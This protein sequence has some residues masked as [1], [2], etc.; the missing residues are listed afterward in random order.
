MTKNVIQDKLEQSLTEFKN[1]I[2]IECGSQLTTYHELDR[3]SNYMANW[4]VK[5]SIQ[6]GTFV[7][8]LADDRREFITAMIALLKVGGVFVALDSVNPVE[9]LRKM[10]AITQLKLI[11][12]D[13][14]NYRRYSGDDFIRNSDIEFVV[15]EDFFQNEEVHESDCRTIAGVDYSPED[16]IYVYFTSGT[17]GLPKAVVGKNKSLLHY[18]E[19]EVDTFMIDESFRMSQLATTGFDAFLKEVFVTLFSGGIL[20]VP[21]DMRL[22][23]STEEL[24]EWLEK[25]EIHLL[26]CVPGIF[27]I[28]CSSDLI[29]SRFPHLR[30]ILMSGEKIVPSN[31]RKWY[32]VFTE[33]V[34]LVNLYGTT[35]TTILKTCYLINPADADKKVI[36]IGKPIRGCRMIILDENMNIC[37]KGIIGEIY[38]RTPYLTYGYYNDPDLTKKRFI[39]NPFNDNPNDIIYR[40]GDLG[41]F[42]L[43]GNVECLG[44]IDRQVKVRGNRI[45]LEEIENALLNY[46]HEGAGSTAQINDLVVIAKK[47]EENNNYLCA[48]FISNQELT[49]AELRDYL[50]NLMPDYMIP[51]YFMRIEK[52]PF[53]PNGKID[54]TALP[55]PVTEID[56]QIVSPRN[57]LEE[58]LAAIW[59][60]VLKMDKGNISVV[61]NFFELGG[62]SL[63]VMSL[64]SLIHKEFDV[65]IPVGDIFNN[66]TIKKQA[67]FISYSPEYKDKFVSIQPAEEKD[68]YP[69]SSG[70][71]RLYVWQQM[72]LKSTVYNTVQVIVL[73]GKQTVDLLEETFAKLIERHE[74]LRTSFLMI[75]E[76]PVQRVH[77]YGEVGSTFAIEH[78]ECKVKDG[79]TEQRSMA[80]QAIVDCFIRPFDLRQLPLFR[81]AFINAG[82]ETYVLVVDMHHIISD[83]RANDILI[84]DFMELF[85]RKSLKRLKLQYRDFSEWQ[86]RLSR[87]GLE[88]MNRM[89][90]YWLKQFQGEIPV[91]NLPTDFSR[92][93]MPISEGNSVY[94]D[95]GEETA[96]ALRAL[97]LKEGVTLYILLVALFNVLLSRL[98]SQE[99]IIVGIM[100]EG[101]RHVDLENIIGF[102]VNTLPLRN[103][104]GADKPFLEFL[105]E[106]KENTLNALEN[107]D[108][109]FE[110]LLEKLKV[111]R[112]THGNPLFN[113]TIEIRKQENAGPG[114]DGDVQAA[115]EAVAMT[116]T[117]YNVYQ[118]KAPFD[119]DFFVSDLGNHIIIRILYKTE[120][121]KEDTI[122]RFVSYFHDLVASVL[123]NNVIKLEDIK[124][125]HELVDVVP[126]EF[127]NEQGD[128]D[129]GF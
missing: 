26:H 69:L 102:F 123:E 82:S 77:D 128:F 87:G 8:I 21:H 35:E 124:I 52:M 73:E 24:S 51:A 86:H 14:I 25:S 22:I 20:C 89:E 80:I 59:S 95:I 31:L 118:K 32:G 48:Y 79:N 114:K 83:G 68:Y 100:V 122:K 111:D 75:H 15:I 44:R 85:E 38:I 109:P 71:K 93:P 70:Q 39:K 53:L 4:M 50:F 11:F 106:V 64:I 125:S 84:N 40:T 23:L 112:D 74:S 54:M 33:R 30:Y 5:Q 12:I 104:P 129:F 46:R 67:E 43:D 34:Q 63:N 49:A 108:Y 127:V 94:F 121:F 61:T 117:S 36:P 28:L 60:D 65:R 110:D 101:R 72:N 47:D 115:G 29:G 99:D 76:E 120:L 13:R 19:W 113:V 66:P 97:A 107:Q 37:N 7:G 55:D 9:R 10:A 119:L 92:P 57:E 45:E 81:A 58:R 103:F 56:K 27:H 16:R 105:T 126:G 96:E 90:A 42:L 62:H 17:S 1:N 88:S 116:V 2:A 18:A 78:Y 3:R 6:R 41:R 98:S 91:L